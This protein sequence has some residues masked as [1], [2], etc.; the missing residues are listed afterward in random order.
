MIPAAYLL[1]LR[2][3]LQLHYRQTDS[4][5]PST[6]AWA[7]FRRTIEFLTSEIR[8]NLKSLI[9][10]MIGV[11]L[12]LWSSYAVYIQDGYYTVWRD[13]KYSG[14]EIQR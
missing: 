3:I 12:I 13:K 8:R 6:V 5:L 10:S 7:V 9:V 14:K 2:I 11:V 1:A 4:H